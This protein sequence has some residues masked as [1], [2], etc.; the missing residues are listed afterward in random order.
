MPSIKRATLQKVFPDQESIVAVEQ[1]FRRVDALVVPTALPPAAT[2]LASAL[3][4]LNALR[5]LALD[6]GL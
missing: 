4:L 5:Q 2:D 3:A 6:K 1:L